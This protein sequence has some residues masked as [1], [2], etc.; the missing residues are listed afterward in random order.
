MQSTVDKHKC[1]K[2]DEIKTGSK[3]GVKNTKFPHFKRT[4]IRNK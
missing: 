1:P 2:G 4:K 3:C